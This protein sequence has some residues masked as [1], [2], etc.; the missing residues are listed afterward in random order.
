MSDVH[1]NHPRT[2][3]SSLKNASS[4]RRRRVFSHRGVISAGGKAAVLHLRY[5]V[6]IPTHTH[7]GASTAV[8]VVRDGTLSRGCSHHHRAIT[9]APGGADK[10]TP[11]MNSA[12]PAMAARLQPAHIKQTSGGGG[13]GEYRSPPYS[14]AH[15]ASSVVPYWGAR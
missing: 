6:F 3:I 7:G 13:G 8:I 11:R 14:R 5:C 9:R 1:L 15:A 12:A 2:R 4:P 10:N